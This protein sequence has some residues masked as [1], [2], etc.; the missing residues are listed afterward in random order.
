[1]YGKGKEYS[2]RRVFHYGEDFCCNC[3][4]YTVTIN[5]PNEIMNKISVFKVK[6]LVKVLIHYSRLTI[7]D[8]LHVFKS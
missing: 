8:G 5:F 2:P 3:R 4:L 7:L 6:V 1:M